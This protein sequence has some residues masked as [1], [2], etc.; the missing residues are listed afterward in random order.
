MNTKILQTVILFIILVIVLYSCYNI[1]CFDN[2]KL[3][4]KNLYAEAYI[5]SKGLDQ[6]IN[7]YKRINDFKKY[8]FDIKQYYYAL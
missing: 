4:F 6:V 2:K 5:Y 8:P 7:K 1:E 3:K